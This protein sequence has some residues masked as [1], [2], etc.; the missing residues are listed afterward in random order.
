MNRITID[1]IRELNEYRALGTLENIYA[2]LETLKK[3]EAIGAVEEL[4]E[5]MKR[6]KAGMEKEGKL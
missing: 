4:Q 3:Y 1:A 6:K 2:A 5:A